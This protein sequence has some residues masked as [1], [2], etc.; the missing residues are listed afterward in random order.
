MQLPPWLIISS[1][2]GAR[3]RRRSG[4]VCGWNPE[5]ARAKSCAASGYSPRSRSYAASLALRQLPV[6]LAGHR[7]WA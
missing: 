6:S 1:F 4:S 5:R 3:T 7:T 2:A